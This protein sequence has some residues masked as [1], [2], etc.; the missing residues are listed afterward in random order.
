MKAA[1][2]IQTA[3]GFAVAPFSGSVPQDFVER[4]EVATSLRGSYSVS[5]DAVD[6]ILKELFA[7]PVAASA[8]VE[9]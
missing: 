6:G 9:G 5:T 2:V 3:N 7:A 1:L 8:S 4:M